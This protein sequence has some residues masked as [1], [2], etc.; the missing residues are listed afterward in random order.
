MN[1]KPPFLRGCFADETTGRRK[2]GYSHDAQCVIYDGPDAEYVGREICIG[3]NETA[4]SIADVTDKDNPVA[5]GTGSY[6][7]AG[8][9]HQGWLSED[10]SYFYQNDELDEIAGR[11]D[12]TRTLVW[13]VRDLSD[14]IMIREFYG[15]TS[16]TDHNL[17][18]HGDLMY[19]TNNA[20]GLRLIDVSTPDNPVEIGYFDTTPYGT[21]EAGFNGTWSSYP[22][23]KSGIIVVTSRREG[24]FILK[25]Q[26]V[27]T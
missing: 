5:V 4:I 12:K 14:P 17:Y 22:Y 16:A 3:A 7:D 13:D 9:V 2:T 10:H 18:V 19:Q 24:V 26:T 20:S 15:P 8:Y 1:P 25:K 21:D 23:F 6:P 11:V 27:D